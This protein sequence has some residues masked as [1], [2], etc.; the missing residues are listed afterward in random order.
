MSALILQDC[1]KKTIEE[2]CI[3]YK[4]DPGDLIKILHKAQT[5]F[6][7]LPESVQR[8]IAFH[9]KIS[10]AKVY[11]VVTFYSFFTMTPKGKHPISVC[12]GTACYVRGAEKVLD[13][14]KDQLRIKVGGVTENGKFSLDCL[15][16]VGACGLAPVLLIGEKV[17]GRVEASQ[18]KGILDSYQD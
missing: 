7:Y 18:I 5:A 4:N 15:R 13:E 2:I 8:E 17:Y 6:G 11:G 12:M 3:Y 9:L 14:L 10:V 16:C 1:H